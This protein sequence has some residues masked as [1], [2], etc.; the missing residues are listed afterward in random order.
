V[1]PGSSTDAGP[2]IMI[3]YSLHATVL[4]CSTPC[5]RARGVGEDN[6]TGQVACSDGMAENVQPFAQQFEAAVLTRR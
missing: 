3:S 4:Q 2:E 6:A 5:H 1:E